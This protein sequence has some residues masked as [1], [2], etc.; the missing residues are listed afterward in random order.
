MSLELATMIVDGFVL[1]QIPN[2]LLHWISI[3]GKVWSTIGKGRWLLGILT[4]DGY[5]E[6]KLT[7]KRGF[8]VSTKYTAHK[9]VALCWIGPMPAGKFLVLHRSNKKDIFGFLDNHADNL[10]YGDYVDNAKDRYRHRRSGET[11]SLRLNTEHQ[12]VLF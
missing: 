6:I 2:H 1:K 8:G 4:E 3:H 10:Y 7:N 12:K 5:R 9:L 11:G